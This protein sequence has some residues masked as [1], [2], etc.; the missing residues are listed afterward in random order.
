[1]AKESRVY[2][3]HLISRESLRYQ[4]PAEEMGRQQGNGTIL[5]FNVLLRQR[6][7]YPHNYYR[8]PDFQRATWAWTPEDCLSLLE[9]V[10]NYQVVPS[11]IMW[12]GESYVY[13]LDGAHRLSVVMAWFRDDWGDKLSTDEY[14][15]DQQRQQIKAIAQED[16]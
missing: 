2:L 16:A 3:D 6:D 15:D 8:K 4:P 7:S 14:E 11:I 13:V 5:Q 9:S 1:M 12:A 10:V